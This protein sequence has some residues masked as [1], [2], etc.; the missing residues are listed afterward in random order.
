MD[1]DA[2][3]CLD[4]GNGIHRRDYFC[5]NCGR[6]FPKDKVKTEDMKAM[7]IYI[8]T[9]AGEFQVD[10]NG[11]VWHKRVDGSIAEIKPAAGLLWTPVRDVIN[12]K[13]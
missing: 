13:D 2:G 3:V 4:C 7:V 8:G 5:S 1:F 10:T 11:V 9:P 6:R 12:N